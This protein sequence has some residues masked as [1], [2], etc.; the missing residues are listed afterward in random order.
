MRPHSCRREAVRL[1]CGG[2]GRYAPG[3]APHP[4]RARHVVLSNLA[5]GREWT[6]AA[7]R[8]TVTRL[9]HHPSEDVAPRPPRPLSKVG[10]QGPSTP[11][12][13]M[14]RLAPGRV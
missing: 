2:P 14:V 6:Q 4:P 13:L 1:V 12:D 10:G 5:E 3:A 11:G 7:K 8:C 9:N